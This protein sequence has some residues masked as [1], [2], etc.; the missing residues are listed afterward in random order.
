ML[1]FHRICIVIF[2]QFLAT[3]TFCQ[4]S[5]ANEFYDNSQHALAI[6]YYKKVSKSNP[7]QREEAMVKLGNSYK[8]ISEFD[9]AEIAYKEAFSIN[10]QLPV[11]F[12]Y[13]YAEILKAKTKYEQAVIQYE[14]YIKLAPNDEKAKTA[15]KFCQEIK[16]YLSKPIEYQVKNLQS[17]NTKNSEFSPFLLKDNLIYVSERED[18]DFSGEELNDYDGQSYLNIYSSKVKKAESSKSKKFSKNIDSDFHDGPIC[19]NKDN[20]TLYFTRVIDDGNKTVNRAKIYIAKG[21]DSK[22]DSIIEFEHNS[23]DYSLAHPCISDDN[24]Y[25]FFV[26]DMPGGFGGKD[27]WMSEK[28]GESWGLPKNLGPDINTSRNELYPSYKSDS[29]LFFSSD[30]LPGFGG[31]DIYSA[32]KIDTKWILLRNE[33]LNLNSSKDDFGITFLNDSAGYFSSDRTGGKGKDDIY[34]FNYKSKSIVVDGIVL[35][36]EDISDAA[37]NKK[38]ILYDEEGKAI[39]S[40]FT[41]NRGYFKFKNISSE[42]KYLAV[43]QED[44]PELTGKARYYLAGKD[45]VISRVT[46]KEGENKFAFK[47]LPMDPSALPILN[48]QDD[49]VMAGNLVYGTGVGKPLK[50]TKIKLTNEFGD[51]V[52]VATTNESGA[53]SF[54]NLPAD[55][56]YIIS[57]VESDVELPEGTKIALK[58]SSGKELK[59]FVTNKKENFDFKIL[60]TD[61]STIDDMLIEDV[62][63]AMDMYGFMYNQNR[64]PII[65]AKIKLRQSDGPEEQIWVTSNKGKFK[66][67]ELKSNK[68]YFFEAVAKDTSLSRVKRIY[69]SDAKGTIYKIIDLQGGKF[70]FKLLAIDKMA[71]G[72]LKMD[73]LILNT[74]LVKKKKAIVVNKIQP[75]TP[76]KQ[77]K[78]VV[79]DTIFENINYE[80][81][82]FNLNEK[83][84]NILNK[85]AKT[86]K[87]VPTLSVEI[88]S[89]ADSRGKSDYNIKLSIKRATTILDY[90]VSK[91][92]DPKRIIANGFGETALI[93][94]CIDESNCSDDDH[95]VNRRTEFKLIKSK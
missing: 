82:K 23:D 79:I 41:D 43:I 27:I 59:S 90:L 8:L 2:V 42:K 49:I 62:D 50:N 30:G 12:Y 15:M 48:T 57:I 78:D 61:K 95:K 74:P 80:V 21:H 19:I 56:N 71:L 26:S 16:Y 46:A 65:N 73:E 87:S 47:S 10:I 39:D 7:D 28:Q 77:I 3:N 29:T 92:V 24:K 17:L 72:E 76:L 40:T 54:R 5:K 25:L 22:W 14:T 32:K 67:K 53:F 37:K 33:G 63:L 31:L 52:E 91:G 36:T 86:L 6:K 88:N 94:Q 75:T 55:Q 69:L 51:V 20:N 64:K 18:F 34:S 60:N 81:A 70:I 89:H 93:N 58:N 66:F 84:K 83:D 44:D 85:L 38:V 45:S 68:N 35:L 1:L 4:L 13:N 9:E 11:E